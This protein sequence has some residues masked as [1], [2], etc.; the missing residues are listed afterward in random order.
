MSKKLRIA[1]LALILLILLCC[2]MHTPTTDS[3]EGITPKVKKQELKLPDLDG[4]GITDGNDSDIDGDGVL[5]IDEEK[6]NSNPFDK[7]TDADGK[8]DGEEFNKDTDKDGV[9]DVLESEKADK[10]QDGVVDELD[11]DDSSVNND[12][13]GDGYS[14]IE[15]KKAGT[16]PL[17]ADSKPKETDTDKDGKIDKIEKG[18]DTDG[19]GKSD[20]VESA[21]LDADNDGVVDELDAE[22]DNPNN[23]TD[24]DGMSNIDE[25][26]AGTNPLDPN[27]KVEPDTDKDGKIDKI[28]KG[29]DADGDGKSDLVESAKLDADNDG[30]VDELDADDSDV[31]NDSDGDGV[32]NIDEKNAG[33]NP[34][35]SNDKPE[36]KKDEPQT[37]TQDINTTTVKVDKKVKEDIESQIKDILHLHKI[38]FETNKAT[39]TPK[40][41]EIVDRV[42][43]ILKKYPG[44]K[45]TIEGH[46]DS[47]GKADY[48]LKLSQDRVDTVKAELVK[49]G[50]SADRLKAVGYGE[51]NP[52]VPNDSAENK[53]KNRRVEFKVI[54]GE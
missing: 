4:D 19:D 14:N 52:L 31:N 22:D 44:V 26:K 33:T 37:N 21:K 53:A 41:K 6:I 29:K 10:D 46:T 51:S 7:D 1:I 49:A 48:N 9:S 2:I 30:V 28:E 34:L 12:S 50:I 23:D 24:N 40:G 8:S 18:K 42:A 36:V 16:N 27:S 11:A 39:L 20:V 13:D 35:D 45:I 3:K 32:S 47:D 17:D 43:T 54:V 25:V 38:E 5:N 15:E